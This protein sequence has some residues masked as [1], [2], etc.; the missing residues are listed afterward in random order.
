VI[1]GKTNLHE[2][3]WGTTSEDSAFGPVRNPRDPSRSPGGSSGGSAAA[4]AAG[5]VPA[6]I[7]TDTGGSVRIPAAWCGIVGLK[8]AHGEVP[9]DGVLPLAPSLDHVGVLAS[10]V[11]DA[12]EVHRVLAGLP[13]GD[14]PAP[15][16][17]RGLRLAVLRAYFCDLLDDDVRRCFGGALDTIRRNGAQLEDVG[18]DDAG[19]IPV[20]FSGIQARE[21]YAAHAALL[22][23]P[24]LLTPP[25]RERLGAAANVTRDQ[26][27][28]A[29]EDARRL[30]STVDRELVR[31]AGL[32]LPTMAFTA[33]PLGTEAVSIGGVAHPIRPLM[34]RLTQ[35]F[36][37]T[38]HP[39]ISIPMGPSV[40][41][42][43]CGL[44]IV[45]RTTPLLTALARGIERALGP[46]APGA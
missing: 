18:I 22:A 1:P 20:T 29:L 8:P 38:G 15:Q 13:A 14:G 17:M 23:A 4:V 26:Y 19:L 30:R 12:W 6:A 27:G 7:G 41:G 42:M 10:T 40:S 45:A 21:A 31:S 24:Q 39:A 16:D 34:L 25:V 37:V 43:P 28:R 32:L 3:A 11:E 9:V 36:N 5:L 33:P 46:T 44:Q 2:L 35:L